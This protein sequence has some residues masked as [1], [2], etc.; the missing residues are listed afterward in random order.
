MDFQSIALTTELLK[1]NLK[2]HFE[3]VEPSAYNLEGYR[4]IQLS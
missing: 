1:Q 2:L 4:S 3:G